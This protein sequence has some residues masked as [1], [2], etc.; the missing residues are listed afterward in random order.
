MFPR[1]KPRWVDQGHERPAD[2]IGRTR[3]KQSRLT[4]STPACGQQVG[5]S[6]HCVKVVHRLRLAKARMPAQQIST[7]PNHVVGSG[8][9]RKI[10]SPELDHQR[11]GGILVWRFCHSTAQPIDLS[12]QDPHQ[13][14][15]NSGL[16][17]AT[18]SLR[19]TDRARPGIG[20]FLVYCRIRSSVCLQPP[21]DQG[22]DRRQQR[23][24]GKRTD[25]GHRDPVSKQQKRQTTAIG[26]ANHQD[27]P[28]PDQL[29]SG[30]SASQREKAGPCHK[31]HAKVKGNAD[32]RSDQDDLVR[33]GSARMDLYRHVTD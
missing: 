22:Q 17:Q 32:L 3:D 1:R 13:S 29:C 14:H 2:P 6:A 15:R 25:E 5:T 10:S 11:H 4:G 18:A 12:N 7:I 9:Y 33:R 20:S 30:S 28:H 8:R 24:H 26:N 19:L 27:E 23:R 16:P 21:G 31:D